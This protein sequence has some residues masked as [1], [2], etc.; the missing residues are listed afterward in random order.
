MHHKFFIMHRLVK[1][2]GNTHRWGKTEEG[3]KEQLDVLEE[4]EVQKLGQKGEQV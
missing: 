1:I 3:L 2:A 4:V